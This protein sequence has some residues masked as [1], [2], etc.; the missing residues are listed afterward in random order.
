MKKNKNLSEEDPKHLKHCFVLVE[1][2]LKT[3]D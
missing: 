3:G 1:E 2:A